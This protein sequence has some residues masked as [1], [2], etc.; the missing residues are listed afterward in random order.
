[1]FGYPDWAA[2]LE[3][4]IPKWSPLI[5]SMVQAGP[6]VTPMIASSWLSAKA[7]STAALALVVTFSKASKYSDSVK[8]PFSAA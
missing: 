4:P 1:M 6:P 2:G 8:S 5:T 7:L 3:L